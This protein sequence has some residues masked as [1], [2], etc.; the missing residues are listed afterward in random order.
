MTFK[1]EVFNLKMCSKSLPVEQRLHLK[2]ESASFLPD[3]NKIQ[4]PFIQIY[5]FF[6]QVCKKVAFFVASSEGMRDKV[7]EGISARKK[8]LPTF[9][10]L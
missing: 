4:I 8:S 5:L 3:L 2:G 1:N 7:T 6:S 9:A 10:T